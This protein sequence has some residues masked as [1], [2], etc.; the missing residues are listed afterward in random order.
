M[1]A[2]SKDVDP[3]ETAEWLE[4]FD[5]LVQARG[6]DRARQI[7]ESLT[8]SGRVSPRLGRARHRAW[9]PTTSTPSRW[10]TSPSSPATRRSSG[11]TAG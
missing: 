1:S 4:S 11:A 7:L 8:D 6:R 2:D 9:S 10:T 5:D 3:E